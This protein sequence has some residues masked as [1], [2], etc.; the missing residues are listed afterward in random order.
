MRYMAGCRC[1]ACRKANAEYERKMKLDRE[2]YGPNDLVSTEGVK[3][4]LHWLAEQGIGH[5]T[6]GKVTGVGKTSLADILWYGKQL[7]RRRNA[8]RILA[9]RPS[10]DIMPKTHN[11]DASETVRKIRTLA[12]WG[13]PFLTISHDG[14]KN[15]AALQIK[16]LDDS[17]KTVQVRTAIKIRDYF[18]KVVQIRRVWTR[19]KGPIPARHYVYWKTEWQ[20]VDIA[21]LEL[22]PFAATYDYNHTYPAE[23]KAA[24]RIQNEL[25]RAYRARK[26]GRTNGKEHHAGSPQPSV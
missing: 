3:R 15:V 7:M 16:S 8:N 18:D 1:D 17:Q 5:K 14:L 6:V 9:L 21:A 2:K 22:R 10:L 26:K 20:E 24:M 23:L 4:H 11:L 13:I 25:K 12:K 19:A